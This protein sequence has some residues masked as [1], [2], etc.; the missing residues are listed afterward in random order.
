MAANQL[1]QARIN[2]QIKQ[3]AS[4]ILESIG[5]TVSDAVRMMLT[6]VVQEKALPF[7]P[8]VPNK[9]TLAAMKDARAGKLKKFNSV[10][11]LMDDLHA[12]D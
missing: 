7:E 5:L 12:D 9:K 6:K 11:S 3:E 10:Q 8:L 2:G 1:V 4:A